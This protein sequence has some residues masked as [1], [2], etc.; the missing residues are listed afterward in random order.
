L[1]KS[2][3]DFDAAP[4]RQI[5]TKCSQIKH[6]YEVLCP[7]QTRKI[8]CNNIYALQRY[9]NFCVGTFYSDSPC[10]LYPS[11]LSSYHRRVITNHKR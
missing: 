4:L 2:N 3:V 7:K 10:M 8:W 5:L 11:M 9:R 6:L 1:S